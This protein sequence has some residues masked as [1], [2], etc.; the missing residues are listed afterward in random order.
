MNEG[1]NQWTD[2]LTGVLTNVQM[3][4]W[5]EEWMGGGK[6]QKN[7]KIMAPLAWRWGS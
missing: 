2:V 4:G 7:M 5:T 3:K 1:T 6:G